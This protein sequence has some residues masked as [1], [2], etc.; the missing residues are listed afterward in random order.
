MG[1]W[2]L[3]FSIISQV[4][5][6]LNLGDWP[7]IILFSRNLTYAG[8]QGSLFQRVTANN[9]ACQT[10][11]AIPGIVGVGPQCFMFQ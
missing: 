9:G 3:A 7:K 2:M 11:V 5:I 1:L 8:Q 4:L 10:G 6:S